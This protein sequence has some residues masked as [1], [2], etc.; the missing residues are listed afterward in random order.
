MVLSLVYTLKRRIPRIPG[1]SALWLRIHKWGALLATVLAL[2]H[3]DLYFFGLAAVTTALMVAQAATG[4]VGSLMMSRLPQGEAGAERE[5]QAMRSRLDEARRGG[6]TASELAREVESLARFES[7]WA[8]LLKWRMVH[9]PLA[10]F[11]L[12]TLLLHI[13]SVY[14]Y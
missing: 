9:V 12:A 13:V 4:A 10:A 1:S 5:I 7:Q 2:L 11:F 3:T 6:A 8:L 14:Y